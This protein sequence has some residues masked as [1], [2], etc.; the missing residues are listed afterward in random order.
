MDNQ[1]VNAIQRF[2]PQIYIACHIDHVRATSTKWQISS[3]DA[4]ILV[5]LDHEIGLNARALADHLGVV[6]STLSA[7]ISR[8]AKLG[9][10]SSKPDE[11]DRRK[12]EIRL[13]PRGA[14][15]IAATSVLDATRVQAMLNLLDVDERK[16]AVRGLSLLARAARQLS[17]KEKK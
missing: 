15:A 9:Y 4:S 10:L 13:T 11:K 12:R 1:D 8:L 17:I 14:Q 16:E 2:Y 6:P 3:Q 5:H 7:A